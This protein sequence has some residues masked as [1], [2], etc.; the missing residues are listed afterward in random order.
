[1][2]K[3]KR[4]PVKRTHA[5]RPK[6]PIEKTNHLFVPPE[7]QG[8]TVKQRRFCEEYLTDLNGQ[9]AALR[10]GYSPASAH[11]TASQAL[12]RRKVIKYINYLKIQ[13]ARRL[14]VT[15]DRIIQE[16]AR[17]AYHDQRTFYTADHEAV[18]LQQITDDQ[19]TAIKNIR[20]RNKTE[21]EAVE[22]IDG[23][24]KME[25]VTR[26]IVSE[27]TFYS[28]VD[29]LRM[30]GHHVGMSLDKPAER[31]STDA[32]N[33]EAISFEQLMRKLDA[34]NLEKFTKL[35]ILAQTSIDNTKPPGPD[36]TD[37]TGYDDSEQNIPADHWS[38]KAETTTMQ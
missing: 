17:I 14:E 28:R 33:K 29:A 10:A 35:L 5:G 3:Y 30:L 2:P 6:K 13:R 7:A 1:M 22:D 36:E 18:P 12:S 16:L 8:L 25:K 38:Q 34:Q 21:E 31:Q 20:F 23:S 27:Y 32:P 26:R 19:Q 4:K 24:M 15:Q 9:Q 11:I 37:E